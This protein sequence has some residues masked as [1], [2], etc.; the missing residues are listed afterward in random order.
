MKAMPMTNP[1]SVKAAPTLFF[2]VN[3]SFAAKICSMKFI[4]KGGTMIQKLRRWACFCGRGDSFLSQMED[5]ELVIN[6]RCS[7]LNLRTRDSRWSWSPN[8][9]TNPPSWMTERRWRASWSTPCLQRSCGRGCRRRCPDWKPPSRFP[10]KAI[11]ISPSAQNT[12]VD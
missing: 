5:E 6:F 2:F 11:S 10:S 4:I 7:N 9:A 3:F 8:L 12:C 1:S